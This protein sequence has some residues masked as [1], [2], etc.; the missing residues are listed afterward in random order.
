M[1]CSIVIAILIVPR[2]VYCIF[3]TSSAQSNAKIEELLQED[4]NAKRRREKCQKQSS[5][6]SKLTRQLS[7]HDN[8]AASYADDS[9]GAGK[10][11]NTLNPAL[12]YTTFLLSILANMCMEVLLFMIVTMMEKP[13]LLKL[14]IFE[15]MTQY[16]HKPNKYPFSLQSRNV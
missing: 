15:Y 13:L 3:L 8:R 12:C 1:F 10:L 16:G 11:A 5:L 9:S 7:I 6:L 14:V 4:H 2:W